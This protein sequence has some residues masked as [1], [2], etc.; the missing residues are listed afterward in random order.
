M[1]TVF[2]IFD[3]LFAFGIYSN[4]RSQNTFNGEPNRAGGGD[5]YAGL[6][7]YADY[8]AHLQATTMGSG[9]AGGGGAGKQ[10]NSPSVSGSVR[11]GSVLPGSTA[12]AESLKTGAGGT[13]K[14]SGGA[15]GAGKKTAAAAASAA[16]AAQESKSGQG[17]SSSTPGSGSAG[18]TGGG[19]RKKTS[20]AKNA[21]STSVQ[22][23]GTGQDAYAHDH[24]GQRGSAGTNTTGG[25]PGGR[26]AHAHPQAVG[27]VPGEMD[28]DGELDGDDTGDV[29]GEADTRLY[30]YCQKTSFG[31]MIG[32]DDDACAY[33]WVSHFASG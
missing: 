16:A 6:G 14:K 11:G 22:S 24:Y 5:P 3:P 18:G 4:P 17:G 19:G 29:D 2:S 10:R 1:L 21:G 28:V 15:G 31:E 7:G 33:E 32:C 27:D 12:G 30:C 20:T 26:H 8:P 13:K 25:G 23:G 9:G